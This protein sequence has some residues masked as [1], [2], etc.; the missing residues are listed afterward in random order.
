MSQLEL[1]GSHPT[2]RELYVNGTRA[3]GAECYLC[4]NDSILSFRSPEDFNVLQLE[5]AAFPPEIAVV[6]IIVPSNS[7][8]SNNEAKIVCDLH[9]KNATASYRINTIEKHLY[10]L[11]SSR[12]TSNVVN[13]YENVAFSFGLRGPDDDDETEKANHTASEISFSISYLSEPFSFRIH[14]DFP[15]EV[16]SA[17][18]LHKFVSAIISCLESGLERAIFHTP[19]GEAIDLYFRFPDETRTACMQYLT[20]FGQFLRDLDI[21]ASTDIR[22]EAG[23]VLFSVVPETGP[24]ALDAIRRALNIYLKLPSEIDHTSILPRTENIAGL[25]LL[26]NV[27]HLQ[28]QLY[29]AQ[30]VIEAKN[31]TIQTAEHHIALL[32]SALEDQIERGQL[33][34]KDKNEEPLLGG[35]VVLQEYQG[36]GWKIDLPR[37]FRVLSRRS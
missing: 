5:E 32:A 15:P 4:G 7:S 16:V 36:K 17:S 3:A 19:P 37:L 6:E 27:Q 20:Y 10:S 28:S 11:N 33:A 18:T 12:K 30:A 35:M 25:Q 1:R 21:D 8:A 24:D 34:T 22:E 29:L 13:L 2:I 9:A 31:A 23:Q 14:A 26:S